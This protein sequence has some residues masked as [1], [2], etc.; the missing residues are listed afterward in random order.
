MRKILLILTLVLFISFNNVKASE[1]VVINGNELVKVQNQINK[2][3]FN[4]LNSNAIDKRSIF[5]FDTS[6]RINA[7]SSNRDRQ[8]VVYRGLY[9]LLENEDELAA[10]LGHEISHSVDSYDGILR[11]YFSG[12]SY[13]WAPKKY[14]YKADKRAVDYMVAAGYNPVAMII[15][16]NKTF[17]QARYD[18]CSTHPLTSRRMMQVYEY[19]YKKY[20]EYLAKNE[21]K[22]NIYYQNFLLTSKNNRAKFQRKI[23][24][25]SKGNVSYL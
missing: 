22:N 3:G 23:E 4:I 25:K 10:V 13:V 17:P 11:G 6:S 8:I 7:G 2:V 24:T 14:E 21:Y 16:M 5:V 1:S 12:L 19:I 18:W 9:N 15:V 20:P